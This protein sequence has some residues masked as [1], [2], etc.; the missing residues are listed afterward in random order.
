MG[1]P[2]CIHGRQRHPSKQIFKALARDFATY[3]FDL[4][5]TE[6]DLLETAQQRVE[7]RRADLVA[8]VALADGQPFILPIEIQNDNLGIMPVPRFWPISCG[9][10]N[11]E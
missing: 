11:H 3:L 2:T 10:V 8:T 7:E 4:A 5:V 9:M 1:N 6:V